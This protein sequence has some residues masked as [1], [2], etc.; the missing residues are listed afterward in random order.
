MHDSDA[1]PSLT[2]EQAILIASRLFTAY[3]LF[4]VIVDLTYLPREVLSVV[5]YM[6]TT[7]S[8]LGTNT[9]MPLS[10]YT[11]R[12]DMLALIENLL[13]ILFWIMA[14]GWFYRC[15]PRIQQFFA[16]ADPPAS[17]ADQPNS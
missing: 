3:L 14:A 4:W 7:A 10:S 17:E 8:V 15:G 16:A 1:S 13:H 11:L 6:K 9:N 5:H 2:R 12:Y